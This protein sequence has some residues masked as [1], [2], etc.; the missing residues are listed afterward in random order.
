[1]IK[2]ALDAVMARKKLQ[3]CGGGASA[4]PSTRPSL[5]ALPP[6]VVAAAE[7]TV[8]DSQDEETLEGRALCVFGPQNALRAAL[9]A[10]I[11]HPRFEQAIIVLIC[12]SSI[13]LALDSPTIDPDGRLKQ[14]LVRP[15]P[16]AALP[17]PCG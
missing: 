8:P 4:P 11:W 6:N 12:A 13:T 17:P 10:V 3:S 9:A 2:S 7:H 1:M 16:P 5:S 14:V 15:A